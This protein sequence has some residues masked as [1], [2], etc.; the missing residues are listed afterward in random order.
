MKV[1]KWINRRA[2]AAIAVALM[3][4]VWSPARATTSVATGNVALNIVVNLVNTLN[5]TSSSTPLIYPKSIA[6]TNGTGANQL[7][8]MWSDTRTLSASASEDLDINGT[9]LTDAYGNDLTFTKVRIIAVCAAAGN[10]NN[11][12]VGN[13]SSNG[14]ISFVGGATHTITVRPGGC[15][16]LVAPDATAYTAAASTAHLLHVANSSSG[17]SVTYDVAIAG[18]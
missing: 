7:A 9:A 5:L 4:L 10:T 12:I 8:D 14:F 1:R 16:I 11:V 2:V 6:F 18:S 17:T 13:A 3:F 15:M